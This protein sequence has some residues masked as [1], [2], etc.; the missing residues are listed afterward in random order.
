MV[1]GNL[2]KGEK[3]LP[4]ESSTAVLIGFFVTTRRHRLLNVHD[5]LQCVWKKTFRASCCQT[6]PPRLE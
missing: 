1:T 4:G 3:N 2:L 6:G 5:V